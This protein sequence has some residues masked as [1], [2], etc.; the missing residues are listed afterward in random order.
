MKFDLEDLK[1][2]VHYIDPRYYRD[3]FSGEA[4][5]ENYRAYIEERLILRDQLAI[6][7]TILANESTFLS[8]IRT[9]LAIVATGATIIHFAD[10]KGSNALGGIFL[11]FG[12]SMLV[13]GVLR[14][15][16]MKKTIISVREKNKKNLT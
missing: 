14:Y 16:R 7:R 9:G 6:D 8:Y 15:K 2:S 12:I 3:L 10:K 11:V 4:E 5:D 1:T 13:I